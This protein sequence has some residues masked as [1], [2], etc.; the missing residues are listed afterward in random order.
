MA[1]ELQLLSAT[2]DHAFATLENVVLYNWRRTTTVEGVKEIARATAQ[3]NTS[4]MANAVKGPRLLAF[5][6]VEEGASLP[7]AHI[8]ELMGEMMRVEWGQT[9]A[10]SA[11]VF[12][13]E[14]F[15]ASAVRGVA[16]GLALLARNAFPHKA[17]ASA[18]EGAI[19]LHGEAR[20]RKI[21]SP[22]VERLEA[23]MAMLRR[24]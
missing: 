20:G 1:S 14:G 4:T 7:P 12:V 5:G 8:R 16:T 22:S 10:A 24:S 9:T 3:A 2:A 23:A 15:R 21:M 11:L 19:W 17:F 13:G 6:T 18:A